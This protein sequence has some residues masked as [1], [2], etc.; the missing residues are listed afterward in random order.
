MAVQWCEALEVAVR[1]LKKNFDVKN[2][3]DFYELNACDK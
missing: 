2:F 1:A 3:I